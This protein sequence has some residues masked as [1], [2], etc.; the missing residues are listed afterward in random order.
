MKKAPSRTIKGTCS[1]FTARQR[2][3]GKVMFLHEFVCPQHGISG[4]M[5]FLGV[6]ISGP[7]S[8]PRVG[9]VKGMGMSRGGHGIWEL[10]RGWYSPLDM[11]PQRE[12]GTHPYPQD[13]GYNGIWSPSGR[14]AS[15]WNAVLASNAHKYVDS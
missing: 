9:Y 12:W 5:S 13:M 2:S 7:R 6:G 3:C 14:Y 15:Y 8:L 4:P 1:L 11:A 10:K